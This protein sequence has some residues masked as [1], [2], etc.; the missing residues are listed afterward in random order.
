MISIS[1]SALLQKINCWMWV[2]FSTT[3]TAAAKRDYAY[4]YYLFWWANKFLP[5]QTF[6]FFTLCLASAFSATNCNNHPF[7]SPIAVLTWIKYYPFLQLILWIEMELNK[8][9]NWIQS[10]LWTQKWNEAVKRAYT[11]ALS[12]YLIQSR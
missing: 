4:I 10:T 2:S 7:P 1:T 11:W 3:A 6:Y 5:E 12:Q 9:L 8:C